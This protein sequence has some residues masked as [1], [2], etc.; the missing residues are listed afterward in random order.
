MMAL[1]LG[2]FTNSVHE[3]QGGPEIGKLVGAREVMLVDDIPLRR[4]RQLLMNFLKRVSLQR[5]H[6][7]PARGAISVGE[8]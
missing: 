6:T 3:S 2:Q 1:L 7:A 5:R 4:L 8:S